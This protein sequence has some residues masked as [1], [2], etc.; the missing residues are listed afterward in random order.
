VSSAW[1]PLGHISNWVRLSALCPRVIQLTHPVGQPSVISFWIYALTY[2]G[3]VWSVVF[4]VSPEDLLDTSCR[5]VRLSILLSILRITSPLRNLRR[6]M[7]FIGGLFVLMWFS[8]TITFVGRRV[9]GQGDWYTTPSQRDREA[10]S[11]AIFELIS[12]SFSV[13]VCCILT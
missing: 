1:S 12:T 8:L 3:V 13:L 10:Q 5:L 11:V 7:L 6:A 2:P 4:S 9:S